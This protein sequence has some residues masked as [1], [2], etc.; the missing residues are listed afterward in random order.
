[1]WSETDTASVCPGGRVFGGVTGWP[2]LYRRAFRPGWLGV[3]ASSTTTAVVALADDV[4][5]TDVAAAVRHL[6]TDHA[7]PRGVGACTP[8]CGGAERWRPATLAPLEVVERP[9]RSTA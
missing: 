2:L 6:M 7:P 5:E 9:A 8:A 1:M 4:P 3:V